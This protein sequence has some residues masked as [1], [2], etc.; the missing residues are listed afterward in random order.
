MSVLILALTP[1][2]PYPPPPPS[3]STQV[4]QSALTKA[5]VRVQ[6]FK[7]NFPLDTLVC[8]AATYQPATPVPRYTEVR[9]LKRVLRPP[10]T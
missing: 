5:Y 7:S 6:A 4:G 3:L 2:S 10:N 8:N 1:L 9:Q